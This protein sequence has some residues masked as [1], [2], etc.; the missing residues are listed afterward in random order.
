MDQD[1][2]A[3]GPAVTGERSP[4]EIRADLENTR[5]ELG[6]TAEALAEKTDV[7]ARAQ[8]RVDEVK[9]NVS[10]HVPDDAQELVAKV[11]ANPLPLVGVAVV[12]CAYWLGR[13][14]ARP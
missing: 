14:S 6:D 4:E 1:P 11:R 3:T 10:A 12:V 9:A 7:K 2:R 5:R 8:E 13:R